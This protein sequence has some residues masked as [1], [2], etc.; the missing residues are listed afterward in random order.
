MGS[1]VT[2]IFAKSCQIMRYLLGSACCAETH[3]METILLIV[4]R[5]FNTTIKLY[6]Y[7]CTWERRIEM[8]MCLIGRARL[9]HVFASCLL[10]WFVIIRSLAT[11]CENVKWRLFKFW[12]FDLINEN[13]YMLFS[14][15]NRTLSWRRVHSLIMFFVLSFRLVSLLMALS[16]ETIPNIES[17]WSYSHHN[18]IITT[19]KN[20]NKNHSIIRFE[21]YFSKIETV[22]ISWFLC[23]LFSRFHNAGISQI[24]FVIWVRIKEEEL[25]HLN[26]VKWPD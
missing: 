18:I 4:R 22:I 2:T 26:R 1:F 20:T 6:F 15:E 11:I 9:W 24:M 21:W 23:S 25:Y 12:L 13:A 8:W 17:N 14:S 10:T 19:K 5:I 16:S 3:L 7:Y